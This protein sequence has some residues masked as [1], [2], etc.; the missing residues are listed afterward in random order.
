MAASIWIVQTAGRVYPA[1]LNKA[2]PLAG[3]IDRA[4]PSPTEATVK[5][6]APVA[7]RD[8]N[9]PRVESAISKPRTPAPVAEPSAGHRTDPAA[10]DPA[11]DRARQSGACQL[12]CGGKKATDL[13]HHQVRAC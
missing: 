8:N 2:I 6:V 4:S 11:A 3:E 9:T 5:V 13:R 1:G 7:A 12:A 10:A